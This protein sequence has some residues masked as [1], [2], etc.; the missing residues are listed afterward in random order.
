M[1][2]LWGWIPN[3][4]GSILT[5]EHLATRLNSCADEKSFTGTDGRYRLELTCNAD[6]LGACA[7]VSKCSNSSSL[8]HEKGVQDW[9]HTF[10][11]EDSGGLCHVDVAETC[12]SISEAWSVLRRFLDGNAGTAYSC[13]AMS[14]LVES[15]DSRNV[16][17]KLAREYMSVLETQ[18][19]YLMRVIPNGRFMTASGKGAVMSIYPVFQSNC[20]YFDSFLRAYGFKMTVS[21]LRRNQTEL[22]FRVRKAEFAHD[23]LLESFN[24]FHAGS[25][26]FI[27]STAL[28]VS[29]IGLLV[30]MLRFRLTV[31]WNYQE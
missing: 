14:S 18:T 29:I 17:E 4:S 9:T 26:F 27:I 22:K 19:D 2:V 1:T 6:G 15:D 24:T 7:V 3:L 10:V 11:M 13:S 20:L 12:G 8:N 25:N 31:Y 16:C 5:L 30:A 28:V 23:N 21:E